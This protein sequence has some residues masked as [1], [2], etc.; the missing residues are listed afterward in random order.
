[1]EYDEKEECSFEV[2]KF[3]PNEPQSYAWITIL[4]FDLVL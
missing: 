4:R 1:M 2:C 3:K